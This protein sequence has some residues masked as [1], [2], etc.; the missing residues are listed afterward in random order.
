M[1]DSPAQTGIRQIPVTLPAI[2]GER[3][4]VIDFGKTGNTS[5]TLELIV[6]EFG[7]T[8]PGTGWNADYEIE[9]DPY[10]LDLLDDSVVWSLSDFHHK[11]LILAQPTWLVPGQKMVRLSKE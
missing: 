4:D 7:Q 8:T 9:Y 1:Y 11:I 3:I 2:S 5:K 10:E 6:N